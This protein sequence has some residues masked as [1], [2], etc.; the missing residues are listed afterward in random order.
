MERQRDEIIK[1]QDV[2]WSATS[3]K[4]KA[5][6]DAHDAHRAS[7]V[8]A[9]EEKHFGE[10]RT[11]WQIR[12]ER[13]GLSDD[14]WG[15][16]TKA[17]QFAI[18]RALGGDLDED[19]EEPMIFESSAVVRQAQSVPGPPPILSSASRI[20]NVSTSSYTLVSPAD[21]GSDDELYAAVSSYA[22]PTDDSE[23]EVTSIPVPIGNG[24]GWGHNAGWSPWS[25]NHSSLHG[26]PDQPDSKS[27]P[28]SGHR[29]FPPAGKVEPKQTSSRPLEL[30]L[31]PNTKTRVRG[32]QY[33]GPRIS[34]SDDTSEEEDDFEKFKMF[35]RI[36]KI[37]EFH[38]AA[39][40]ADIDLALSIF[41]G[42]KTKQL[43]KLEEEVKVT[44]HEGRMLEL[45]ATKENERKAIVSAERKKRRDELRSRSILH[46][47][48]QGPDPATYD[49]LFDPSVFQVDLDTKGTFVL[50]RE[51]ASYKQ[52][53]KPV[54]GVSS[55][56][57]RTVAP[58][59]LRAHNQSVG[60][61]TPSVAP[62]A[63]KTKATP[64]PSALSQVH[65]I[66]DEETSAT[67]IPQRMVDMPWSL[68][69]PPLD[70]NLHV[71]G[72]FPAES[73]GK[74]TPVTSGWAKKPSPTNALASVS[75][76]NV[77][78]S[79]IT[80]TRADEMSTTIAS[81]GV[82]RSSPPVEPER[83][84]SPSF[85]S[86][87][88]P[89]KKQ[90]QASKK[91]AIAGSSLDKSEMEPSS[92]SISTAASSSK[93]PVATP[94]VNM[95]QTNISD[96]SA[97]EQEEPSSTPR[98]NVAHIIMKR[99]GQA[100]GMAKVNPVIGA[101]DPA[102][103]PRH[104]ALRQLATT[105]D[106]NESTAEEEHRWQRMM[107]KAQ[108]SDPRSA[109][110]SKQETFG[111]GA[112]RQKAQVPNFSASTSSGAEEEETPW[113]RMMRLKAQG[114][115]PQPQNSVMNTTP[116]T[117][118]EEEEMPWQRS[119]RLKGQN[120]TPQGASML[121]SNVQED[122][123]PWERTMRLKGQAQMSW[124]ANSLT[125]T[126]EESK[127]PWELRMNKTPHR[128][129][130]TINAMPEL[131]TSSGVRQSKHPNHQTFPMPP[132]MR[133]A[134]REFW[135]PGG[136][137]PGHQ[138]WNPSAGRTESPHVEKSS[139]MATPYGR[140]QEMNRVRRM[141]DPVSPSPRLEFA[142]FPDVGDR[143]HF[144]PTSILKGAKSKQ[145]PAKT[146]RV[147]I[148]EISDEEDRYLDEKLPSN[149]R[150]LLDIVEPKPSVPSNMYTR[151]FGFDAEED[152]TESSSMAPT[153]STAP[154]SPPG[155]VP[156]L[157]D[158][159]LM[160]EIKNGGWE[161]LLSGNPSKPTQ[162]PKHARW[163]ASSLANNSPPSQNLDSAKLLSALQSVNGSPSMEEK[164]SVEPKPAS[165]VHPVPDNKD[166]ED[167]VVKPSKEVKGKT[168]GRGVDKRGKSGGRK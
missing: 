162:K 91:S 113:N 38:H 36:T 110:S 116:R 134:D 11:E 56:S 40:M 130:E 144:V 97:T 157:D 156:L 46:D 87:K 126:V 60:R 93:T 132:P 140:S 48:P 71:P 50:R 122:E 2:K 83:S 25:S 92:S 51:D 114:Q 163:S 142:D 20:S 10:A 52:V 37:V 100:S 58:E 78:T 141:S 21:L 133:Q 65:A 108:T 6:K 84:A 18:S 63:W 72:G 62:G 34:D 16:M 17:E 77:P 45:Q 102:S 120:Q 143:Q 14:A 124:S 28:D 3:A 31:K 111:N 33:I 74:R 106:P 161:N 39:A 54:N 27:L 49:A 23:D 90:R 105:H 103:T 151:F 47:T 30:D 1:E 146:K 41:N 19:E 73:K 160:E 7:M 139:S 145:P 9:L 35:T 138:M 168:K 82:N 123:T 104:S 128:G 94:H 121:P 68:T 22:V 12:L 67:P 148:E 150:Y 32:P 76:T 59:I 99:Q 167:P 112:P 165:I 75:V 88:K 166:N 155:E 80:Q 86:S 95:L 118:N 53:E 152:D 158:D 149:S 79:L 24:K 69:D 29:V 109:E 164:V 137:T 5:K 107:M 147:T 153:P 26:S 43:G 135:H 64:T 115:L 70:R 8:R 89:N 13:Q 15:E 44:Q 61:D 85:T 101:H 81:K 98:P 136:I 42:R 154:T 131:S 159:E 117:L 125:T 4:S 119:M 57:S 55:E 66:Y 129:S 127:S 96:F